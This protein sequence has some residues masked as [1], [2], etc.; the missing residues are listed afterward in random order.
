MRKYWPEIV[1][2][3]FA[4]INVGVMFL[5][6]GWETVPFHFVWISLTVLYGVR[7]W[8]LRTTAL[9][10]GATMA[11]TT[12]GEIHPG[13]GGE[14]ETAELFEVV[15]MGLVFLAMVWHARRRQAAL[16][17]VA[18]AAERERDF[19][20]DASH[21]LKTPITVARG[22]AQLVHR[23]LTDPEAREDNAIVIDELDRL[24]MM[25]ER[26]LT[27]A[28]AGHAN[29]LSTEPT[30][31]DVLVRRVAERWRPCAPRNWQV[32]ARP[33][34]TVADPSRLTVAL[35]AIIENAVAHTD[36][37]DQILVQVEHDG[38]DARIRVTDAGCG[39]RPDALGAVFQRFGR[40]DTRSGR[41]GTGLG[42]PMVRAIAEAHGGCARLS[43]TPD[44]GTVVEVRIP[45]RS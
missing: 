26:L 3:V 7:V 31:M 17:L 36:T 35:D 40:G 15:L 43:S 41:R 5:V 37:G 39:I 23:T 19:L 12:L 29:F 42:L 20:R 33:V 24:S 9:I 38:G 22:H 44:V 21:Q 10:L 16:E 4:S 27:L 25:A 32:Q 28:A 1:W 11:A 30:E 13:S 14:V 2:A 18:Q 8:C 34:T 45:V 6:P